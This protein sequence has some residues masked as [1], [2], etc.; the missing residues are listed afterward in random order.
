[1]YQNKKIDFVITVFC[2]LLLSPKLYPQQNNSYIRDSVKVRTLLVTA[3]DCIKSASAN[4]SENLRAALKISAALGSPFLKSLCYSAFA[5][6]ER[7]NRTALLFTYDSL[8]IGNA[9]SSKNDSLLIRRLLN[10]ADDFCTVNRP[11]KAKHL[12]DELLQLLEKKD[13]KQLMLLAIQYGSLRL[14]A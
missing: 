9:R 5:N 14:S 3:D 10:L 13:D 1:M 6:A 4:C 11:E 8:S 7:R 12:I 2:L